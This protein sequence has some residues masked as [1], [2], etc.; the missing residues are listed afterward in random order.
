MKNHLPTFLFILFLAA[1]APGAEDPNKAF[2]DELQQA[3]V[4]F[5]WEEANPDTGLIYDRARFD[6]SAHPHDRVASM[7]GLGF[8]L[9]AICIGQERGW[10]DPDEAYERVLTTLRFLAD[11]MPH[12]RGFYYHFVDIDTGERRWNS[13]LSS[14]DTALLI[15]G[16][17][18]ARQYYKGTE[19]EALATR[20]YERVEWPWM[21]TERGVFSMGW[22][23]E[24][25]FLPHYWGYYSEHKILTLLAMGSPTH[26]VEPE[27]WHRWRREP[28][29]TYGGRTFLACPPLFTHQYSQNW[30]DFRN[31]RDAYADYHLNTVLATRA[32]RDMFIDLS[33]VFPAFGKDL[34]GL[35]ASDSPNGYVA[36]GGPPMTADPA[37]D[38][39]VT[40][41]AAG[42]AISVTPDEAIHTLRHMWDTYG[43]SV[44]DRYAFSVAFNPHTDWVAPDVIGIDIGVTVMAAEN[45]RS[46]FVWNTFM[47]NPE[48]Q[49]A[50]S[51]AGFKD[52]APALPEKDQAYLRD[53]AKDTWR[54][55][56]DLIHTE[57]GLPY[58]D[59]NRIG[60]TSLNH[61]GLYLTAI[62]A[63]EELGLIDE[64]NAA[65]R[66]I[67]ALRS[68]QQFATW[69]GFP[70]NW[71]VLDDLSPSESDAWI[72]PTET[73]IFAAGLMTVAASFP[74]SQAM[75]QPLLEAIEWERFY[76]EERNVLIGGFHRETQTFNHDW[77]LPY[78]AADSRIAAFMAVASGRVPAEL[79]DALGRAVTT[80]H[81]AEYMRPGWSGG[82]L[83]MA[84]MSGLWLDE[85]GTPALQSARN[86]AYA[87]MRHADHLGYPVWG[88]S[89]SDSPTGGFLG[90]GRLRDEI[91][92]P[93]ASVLAIEHYPAEVVENLRMLD[94]MDARD[95]QYG[96][97]DALDVASGRLAR[98][99]MHRH[100][101][102]ILISLA[103]YLEDHAVRN[104]F[105]SHPLVHQGR[106]RIA[107]FREPP[108]AGARSLFTLQPSPDDLQ[109][110][111]QK[112]V[113]AIRFD[114]WQH[115]EW[116]DMTPDE[117]F[118]SGSRTPR[119]E[120]SARFAFAWDDD[121]LYFKA[122]VVTGAVENEYAPEEMFKG[123]CLELFVD[124]QNDGLRWG[125]T[126]DLQFGFSVEDR[127]W[128]W[129]GER[130]PPVSA[131]VQSTPDGYTVQAE[132]P[133]TTLNVEA[134]SGT[135]LQ[136]SPALHSVDPS[137]RTFLKLNWDWEPV[138]PVVRLGLLEL[139]DE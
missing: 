78:L 113:T 75:V 68:I 90:W 46:E 28:V 4:R 108:F 93:H 53:L 122:H 115:A 131:T 135:L 133:W 57:S 118:D 16:V 24:E 60:I 36:W 54:S 119:N 43:D 56:S 103:N 69:N 94:F 33:D 83:Y 32:Q 31:R 125:N 25:G 116:I 34:W 29:V 111:E 38:G 50:M 84:F 137:D 110:R 10:L 22:K 64:D 109:S 45:Y 65:Q 14:I 21:L 80:R 117:S 40:P 85:Q 121:H 114:D 104:H 61:I 92:T 8:G 47:K 62:V 30:I 17:L 97:F 9:T 18:T 70:A 74:E 120:A 96:F 101:C 27:T 13:E 138:G 130:H 100:Q 49:H 55:I 129:F 123:N 39:T 42:G 12:V 99:F 73:A 127:I 5:F 67:R 66:I 3:G 126:D 82:G 72:S 15:A 2:L 7:A 76:D 59:A 88:W 11:D 136:V 1:G 89:A 26:P 44:R 102:M 139:R 51:L 19:V 91:V 37:I 63:A 107:D 77:T 6:A 86:F 20:I 128:E 52:I 132:I 81:H 79:W 106:S 58:N 112:Q 134:E 95:P 23:P 87:Q 41:Y 124:P 48:I 71:Y 35:T 98:N 105:Q